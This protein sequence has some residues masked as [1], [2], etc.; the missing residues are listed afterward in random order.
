MAAG[1]TIRQISVFIENKQGK[2]SA[3]L[4]LL[5]DN[6]IDIRA[7]NIADTK[8]F[9]ILRLIPNDTDKAAAILKDNGY[10]AAVTEVIAIDVDDTPGALAAA[11][12][13]VD[14]GGASV[15]YMYASFSTSGSAAHIIIRADDNAKAADALAAKGYKA[16]QS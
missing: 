16:F 5:G 3:V 13:V 8:D 4:R 11:L 1:M 2:L 14:E 7:M 15:E 10:A 6:S 12:S 9:G